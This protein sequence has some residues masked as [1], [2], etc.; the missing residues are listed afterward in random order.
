LSLGDVARQACLAPNYFS[1]RFHGLTGI[2]FQQY[3]QGLCLCFAA[4]LLMASEL[5]VSEI[6]LA[7][8]FRDLTHFGRVFKKLYRASPRQCRLTAHQV[9]VGNPQGS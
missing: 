1:E 7:A 3:L 5:S 4:R 9:R 6:L 8:G 2:S